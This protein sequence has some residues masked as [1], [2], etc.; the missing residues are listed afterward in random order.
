LDRL[1]ATGPFADLLQHPSLAEKADP[2]EPVP[3]DFSPTVWRE[4]VEA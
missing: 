2:Q 3:G 1:V 4:D